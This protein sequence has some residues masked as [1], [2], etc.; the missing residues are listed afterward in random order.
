M[1]FVSR[2]EAAAALSNNKP[3]IAACKNFVIVM[4]IYFRYL[5]K[6]V[7]FS[8]RNLATVRSRNLVTVMS[9]FSRKSVD[10]TPRKVIIEMS[11]WRD[12]ITSRPLIFSS[13]LLNEGN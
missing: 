10:A 6:A 8:V 4:S 11:F 3:P 1:S 7:L 5:E 2:K 13:W 9:F 12:L